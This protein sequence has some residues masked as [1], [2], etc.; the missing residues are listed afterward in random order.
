VSA[1]HS[2]PAQIVKIVFIALTVHCSDLSTSYHLLSL[3]PCAD[4]DI[5]NNMFT[6]DNNLIQARIAD[7][8]AD[9]SLKLLKLIPVFYCLAK[10]VV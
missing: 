9:T 10:S 3:D 4:A 1:F 5:R 2:K 7:K 8:T 6:A